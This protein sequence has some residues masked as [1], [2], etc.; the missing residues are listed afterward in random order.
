MELDFVKVENTL[1]IVLIV[2]AVFIAFTQLKKGEE[3]IYECVIICTLSEISIIL[4]LLLLFCDFELGILNRE[5]I[6]VIAGMPLIMFVAGI[7]AGLIK[8]NKE[9]KKVIKKGEEEQ[10]E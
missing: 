8:A 2:L 1:W 4:A 6:Y 5:M 7:N 3:K 9:V 10:E